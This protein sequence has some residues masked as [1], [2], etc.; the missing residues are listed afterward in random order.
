MT[1]RH[2]V[3]TAAGRA[4][5][6]DDPRPDMIDARALACQL[7]R[8]GRWSNNLHFPFS[9]GQHSMLVAEAIREPAWRIYGLLH[10]A[11]ES[12]TRD[13][14]TPFKD[15]LLAQGADVRELERKIL[16]QA[17]FPHFGL[18]RPT[19]A[20]AEAVDIADARVLATE[21][22]DVVQGK[23]PALWKPSGE[24][25]GRT[26]RFKRP[27]V[28]EDEFIV[29]LEQYRRLATTPAALAAIDRDRQR[30]AANG[31]GLIE[32]ERAIL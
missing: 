10:D 5:D 15:W 11:A 32:P 20:I 7:S 31:R 17:V 27:D 21:Y 24:P 4:F 1:G 16:N 12:F 9:V 22:R 29:R 30:E 2:W 14:G 23:D 28:V 13:L 6:F 3:F 19:W 26:V 18:P 25:L 8:E